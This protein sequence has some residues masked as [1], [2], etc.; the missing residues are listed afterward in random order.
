[1]LIFGCRSE[2]DDFYYADEWS[3]ITNLTVITAFS[4]A[5]PDAGK[6]YVQH[7]IRDNADLLSDLITK[8]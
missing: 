7:K 6:T 3:K 8:K 1:M 5:S 2:Q 4:R